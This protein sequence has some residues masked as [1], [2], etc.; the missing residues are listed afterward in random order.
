MKAKV[1]TNMIPIKQTKIHKV[2]PDG[3]IIERGN[4]YAACWASLLEVPL[5]EVPAFEDLPDDGSWWIETIK[6]LKDKGLVLHYFPS[7]EA[8][9]DTYV[10]ACGPSPRGPWGHGVIYLDGKLVFDPHP[11][12]EGLVQVNYYLG[13]GKAKKTN[14]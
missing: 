14:K 4:C 6:W 7:D 3:A 2:D 8:P 9:T 10:M 12:G 5:E 11:S 13:A 1:Q